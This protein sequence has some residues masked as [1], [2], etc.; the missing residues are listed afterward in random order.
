MDNKIK[1]RIIEQL[2]SNNR[3]YYKIEYFKKSINDWSDFTCKYFGYGD[4]IGDTMIFR[5]WWNRY[6]L[7]KTKL[8]LEDCVQIINREA[9]KKE[10]RH[11]HKVIEET[12]IEYN[13]YKMKNNEKQRRILLVIDMQND[14]CHPEGSLYVKGA[15]KII[16]PINKEMIV[17]GKYDQIWATQDWHPA[18]H[19]SFA[20]NHKGKKQFDVIK[21]PNGEDQ[22]LWVDHCKKFGPAILNLNEG[23]DGADFVGSSVPTEWTDDSCII[24]KPILYTSIFNLIFRK[25]IDPQIDSYSAFYDN[26]GNPTGLGNMLQDGDELYICGVAGDYC[27]KFSCLGAIQVAK[28]RNLKDVKV[29]FMKNLTA[30]VDPSNEENVIKELEYAGIIIEE[31]Q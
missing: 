27:V 2:K 17:S 29:Y 19:I 14:F 5:L 15:E 31:N 25:G 30:Y 1:I 8:L 24:I 11:H 3:P 4:V 21:A 26:A 23:M 7:E 12:I 22:V 9:A 18:N 13:K 20:S 28:E 6:N 16:D 10:Y